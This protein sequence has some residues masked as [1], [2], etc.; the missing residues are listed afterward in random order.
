MRNIK[1]LISLILI[2]IAIFLG[3]LFWIL[4]ILLLVAKIFLDKYYWFSITHLSVIGTPLEVLVT[5]M[6]LFF[7]G[8]FLKSI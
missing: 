3:N 8:V 6:F 7:I 1:D 4:L 2:V 5:A